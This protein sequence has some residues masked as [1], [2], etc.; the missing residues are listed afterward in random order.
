VRHL[1]ELDGDLGHAARQALAGAEVKGHAVPAPV[2]D[3][4]PEGDEGVGGALWLDA[5]FLGVCRNRTAPDES[6]LVLAAHH[7]HRDVVPHRRHDRAQ[8]LHFFI[9]DRVAVEEGGRLHRHHGQ[10]L[11]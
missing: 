2:V 8:D 7:P 3:L 11:Q 6:G 1:L 10:Q 5:L 9:A 4:Q